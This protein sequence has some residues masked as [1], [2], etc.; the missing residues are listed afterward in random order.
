[1][2]KLELAPHEF[3]QTAFSLNSSVFPDATVASHPHTSNASGFQPPLTATVIAK[4]IPRSLS[5]VQL[6]LAQTRFDAHGAAGEG[7]QLA[8]VDHRDSGPQ[9]R[10]VGVCTQLPVVANR[11]TTPR[12]KSLLSEPISTDSHRHGDTQTNPAVSDSTSSSRQLRCVTHRP[13][14]AAGFNFGGAA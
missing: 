3:K 11:S 8:H 12:K 7:S 2:S 6:P 4:P 1:M 14:A 10:I 9:R 13:H 5:V